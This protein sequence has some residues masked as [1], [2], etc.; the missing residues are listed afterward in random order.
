MKKIVLLV[1]IFLVI[2]C[3]SNDNSSNEITE[4]QL[5]QKKQEVM[6]YINSFECTG[7]C[8]YIGFGSKPCGGPREYLV[9]PSEVDFLV[10]EELVSEYNEMDSLHNIQTSAVSDCMVVMPPTNIDCVNGDCVILK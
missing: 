4:E 2:S 8:N 6:S 3:V 10:L 9:F 5:T 7:S 1:S